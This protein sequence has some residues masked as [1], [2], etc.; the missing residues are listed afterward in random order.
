VRLWDATTGAVLQTL[1]GY[2]DSVFSVTFSTNGNLLS[3]LRISNYWVVEG[4][5]NSLWLP[6]DLRIE[7][8]GIK[9]IDLGH[10][11]ERLSFFGLGKGHSSWYRTGV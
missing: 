4:K 2:S 10:T 3:T 6:P 5:A 9:Q 1:E 7:L 11:S 8:F